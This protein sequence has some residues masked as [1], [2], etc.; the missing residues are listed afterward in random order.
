MHGVSG[1]RAPGDRVFAATAG[2]CSSAVGSDYLVLSATGVSLLL[3]LLRSNHHAGHASASSP[4]EP[5][6]S[7]PAPVSRLFEAVT[8]CTHG[9]GKQCAASPGGIGDPPRGWSRPSARRPVEPSGL[10]GV[11]APGVP[12]PQGGPRSSYGVSGLRAP[13]GRV[14]AAAAGTCSPAVGFDYLVLS[15]IGVSWLLAPFRSNHH[16]GLASASSPT[17][18]PPRFPLWSALWCFSV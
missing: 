7:F 6:P 1:L 15:A 9:G 16:A 13:G 2:T 11:I 3:A 14:F 12:R 17:E 10:V 5:P 8:L 18:S 4:T